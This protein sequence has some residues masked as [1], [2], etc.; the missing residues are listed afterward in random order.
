MNRKQTC[1]PVSTETPT[2]LVS[3]EMEKEE[4]T[5]ILFNTPYE[6]KAYSPNEQIYALE[7]DTPFNRRSQ[8]EPKH[9]GW[10]KKKFFAW[11]HGSPTTS[12]VAH[13]LRNILYIC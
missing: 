11:A 13:K 12:R 8:L 3:K 6:I 7:I 5:I 10:D 4:A 1:S 9:D 2:R